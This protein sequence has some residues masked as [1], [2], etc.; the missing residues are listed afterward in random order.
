MKL[1][2]TPFSVVAIAVVATSLAYLLQS[3]NAAPLAQQ[4]A[5]T[6]LDF[7]RERARV[8]GA[9]RRIAALRQRL[10]ALERPAQAQEGA[11]AVGGQQAIPGRD[12]G[13]PPA[14][15]AAPA[16]A[17][18][19]RASTQ[20]AE[21]SGERRIPRTLTHRD[22]LVTAAEAQSLNDRLDGATQTAR[23]LGERINRPDF[24]AGLSALEQELE[25]LEAEIARYE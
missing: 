2:R 11:S 15:N 9:E 5:Q 20:P 14:G 19:A 21:R 13:P 3:E 8:T 4:R 25:R 7:T 10:A 12:A 17:R 23:A 16:R 18:N 22:R 24:G 6:D 1:R